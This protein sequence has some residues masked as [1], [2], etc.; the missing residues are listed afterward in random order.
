MHFRFGFALHEAYLQFKRRQHKGAL[1]NDIENF[2]V[3]RFYPSGNSTGS[4]KYGTY[5]IFTQ[6]VSHFYP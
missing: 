4:G 5:S 1:N 3:S 6:G 2:M